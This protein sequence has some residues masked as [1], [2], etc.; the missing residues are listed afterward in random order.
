MLSP[1]PTAVLKD[2]RQ[3]LTEQT[4]LARAAPATGPLSEVVST[5]F[6]Q[7]YL[8]GV[9]DALCQVHGAP[10]DEVALGIFG[11]VLDEACGRD[12]T[13]ERDAA[14]EA[15]ASPSK[16][17]DEGYRYGGNEAIGWTRRACVPSALVMMARRKK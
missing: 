16:T 6:G 9:V 3:L 14:I 12:A 2:A 15:L 7:G 13:I 1:A 4:E 8:L 5:P 17:F 10:F 11:V